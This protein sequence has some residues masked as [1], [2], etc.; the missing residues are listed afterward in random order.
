MSSCAFCYHSF[1]SWLVF[2]EIPGL[3]SVIN[4]GKFLAIIIISSISSALLFFSLCRHSNYV[5]ITSSITDEGP[6]SQS[7]GFS[8]SHVWM[9]DLDCKESW[10]PKNWCFWTVVLEKTLESPFDRKKIQSVYPKGNQSWI[11]IRRID[12]EAEAPILW[13]PDAKHWLTGK[14]PDAGKDWRQEMRM[15][16]LD[17]ITDS[18]DMSLSKLQ[19]FGE[20][21]GKLVCC[22]SWGHKKSDKSNWTELN[23]IFYYYPIVLGC[24]IFASIFSLWISV[25]E[26]S[27]PLVVLCLWT[28]TFTNVSLME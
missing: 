16:W 26:V 25:L 14:D 10:V 9:W 19:E 28:V 8:S 22:S 5:C 13:P 27:Q 2:S 6:S 17:G 7:Y 21:Q 3:V 20:G 24:S 15:R 11:F 4:F 1:F 12:A 18:M 23:Y